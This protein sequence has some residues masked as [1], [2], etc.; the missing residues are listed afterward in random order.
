MLVG[1]RGMYR[2][3][4]PDSV[5]PLVRETWPPNTNFSQLEIYTVATPVAAVA[6]P[7]SAFSG[8]ASLL[9]PDAV[10]NVTVLGCGASLR[11]DWGVER[12]AWFEFDAADLPPP[13]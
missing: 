6:D 13:V 9:S 10:T 8:V 5:D 3:P 12:A 11:L 2:P 1:M 7:P 4:Q